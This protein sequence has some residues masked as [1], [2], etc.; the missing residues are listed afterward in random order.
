MLAALTL[1]P[2]LCYPAGFALLEER[3]NKP[4]WILLGFEIVIVCLVAL[5]QLLR[6]SAAGA[7]GLN[8]E[9]NP[10]RV[11]LVAYIGQFILSRA[12]LAIMVLDERVAEDF[13]VFWVIASL[14]AP[15]VVLGSLGSH[16][17][18]QLVAQGMTA[19]VTRMSVMEIVLVIFGFAIL[20]GMLLPALAS[21][22]A[23]AQRASLQNDLKQIELASQEADASAST[24]GAT[25]SAP[26]RIRRDFP[27][28]LLW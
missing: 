15:L 2:L 16:I 5:C 26:P 6:L 8:P 3:L 27:E 4:G 20:A 10:L 18:R 13:A 19:K 21:A 25:G 11:Y 7:R 28:T 17:D 12:V 24:P 23:K 1:L 9:V 22:K 14:V